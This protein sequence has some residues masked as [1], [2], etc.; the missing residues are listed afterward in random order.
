L[1]KELVAL[2]TQKYATLG[3]HSGGPINHL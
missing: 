1:R 3:Y 2:E